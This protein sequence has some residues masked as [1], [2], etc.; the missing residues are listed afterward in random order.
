MV[1]RDGMKKKG[2][3]VFLLGLYSSV[4]LCSGLFLDRIKSEVL[5][6]FFRFSTKNFNV[7]SLFL[8]LGL[9]L[10]LLDSLFNSIF[11]LFRWFDLYFIGLIS[12]NFLEG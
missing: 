9:L 6:I 11:F 2:L 3:V 1:L 4:I 7:L 10:A 8:V 5:F 12:P